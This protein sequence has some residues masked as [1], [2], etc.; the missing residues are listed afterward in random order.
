LPLDAQ[1]PLHRLQHAVRQVQPSILVHAAGTA[2]LAA[3]AAA[4]DGG[5]SAT[6]STRC[7][8]LC[9]DDALCDGVA[10]AATSAAS[11]AAPL[12][13]FCV[14]NTSAASAAAPLPFF[15]VLN[16]SG[17]TGTPQ[18]VRCTERGFLNR[19]E[20]MQQ[21]GQQGQQRQQGQGH[22][23]QQQEQQQEQEQEQEQQQQRSQHPAGPVPLQPRHVVA[24]KTATTF[25]DHLWELL[26]PLL[27]GADMLLV[28]DAW[29]E[30]QQQSAPAAGVVHHSNL[31]VLQADR[32]VQLLAD[33]GVTHL[34]R[35]RCNTNGLLPPA[36]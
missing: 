25:V 28:P 17:S 11:A 14:L 33:A 6:G 1:W 19:Y 16:T 30:Q 15:C 7:H 29:P 23:Q 20:W 9:I 36:A 18:C 10:A 21:Q 3:A 35:G 2:G 5:G 34:V 24:F 27:S 32:L 12:P 26:A 22:Q 4:G 31:A 8:L 13:F